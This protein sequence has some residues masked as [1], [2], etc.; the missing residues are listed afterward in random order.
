MVGAAAWAALAV[1]ARMGIFRAGAME[2]LFL[3][4][5]LVI[6]PLGMELGRVSGGAVR[7]TA[8]RLEEAAQSLQPL[9]AALAIVAVWLPPGKWAGLVAAGWMVVCGLAALGGMLELRRSFADR[10]VRATRFGANVGGVDLAV[11]GA[12]LVASRLGWQPMG[13]QEPIGLLTAVHFHFA[14]FATATIAA[15]TLRYVER[16]GERRWLRRLVIVVAILPFLVAAG[17]VVSPVLKMAAA[18]VFSGSVAVL[19]GFMW[20]CAGRMQDGTGRAFL[21]IA[22]GCVW[23]AMA[24]SVAYAVSDFL[25]SDFLTIPRMASTH[26][27]LNAAGFCLL[28]LLGWLLEGSRGEMF[29]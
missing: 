11:G 23:A 17:F 10:S 3:F 8:R 26:G 20:R 1:L 25:K 21:R 9:G 7:G 14:G 13:I 5:P 24:L 2:L 12:W 22:S 15:T 4:A 27:V 29:G 6:V 16:W 28:G 19:A 18:A